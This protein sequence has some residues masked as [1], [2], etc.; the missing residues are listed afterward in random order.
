MFLAGLKVFLG[1]LGVSRG[2]G[3]FSWLVV[4]SLL[5]VSRGLGVSEMFRC[6]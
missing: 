6:F 2:L 4:S 3:V 1:G 5:S